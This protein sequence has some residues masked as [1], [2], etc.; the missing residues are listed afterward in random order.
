M[1]DSGDVHEAPF[2]EVGRRQDGLFELDAG[3]VTG[4]HQQVI[5]RE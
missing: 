5:H 2:V 3:P 1:L 4:R